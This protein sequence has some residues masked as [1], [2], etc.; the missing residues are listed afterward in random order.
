MIGQERLANS[1]LPVGPWHMVRDGTR[2]P[3]AAQARGRLAASRGAGPAGAGGVGV[4]A[5]GRRGAD[6]QRGR[7]GAA[8]G[9]DQAEVVVR[10][11][12]RG[13]VPVRR[14][15]AQCHP[16]PPAVAAAGPGLPRGSVGRSSAPPACPSSLRRRPSNS[17]QTR[18]AV[19]LRVADQPQL[20]QARLFL[21]PHD[22]FASWTPRQPL[23]T[24]AGVAVKVM[25]GDGQDPLPAHNPQVEV[26]GVD[27]RAGT[28]AA[29]ALVVAV[30]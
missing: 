26:N 27:P 23:T 18:R 10:P 3:L 1:G 14:V 19:A 17:H 2:A 7:A 9:G 16:D 25:P 24:A 15:A 22:A 6:E 29:V 8:A 30:G 28:V 21:P 20:C 5:A 12:R 11:P 13:R 4:R